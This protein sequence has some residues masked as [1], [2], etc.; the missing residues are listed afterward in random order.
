MKPKSIWHSGKGSFGEKGARGSAG[1]RGQDLSIKGK[2]QSKALRQTGVFKVQAMLD[3][4]LPQKKNLSV[5][6]K[7]YTRNTEEKQKL[8]F[9][10]PGHSTWVPFLRR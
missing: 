1:E 8:V 6:E 7:T 2:Q 3:L 5:S 10:L 9:H 4:W